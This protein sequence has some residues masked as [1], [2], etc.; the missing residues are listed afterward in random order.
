MGGIARAG[1]QGSARRALV[2]AGILLLV[3]ARGGVLGQPGPVRFDAGNGTGAEGSAIRQTWTPLPQYSFFVAGASTIE[4]LHGRMSSAMT[5]AGFQKGWQRRVGGQQIEAWYSAAD[6]STA[7]SVRWAQKG[8][9]AQSAWLLAGRVRA[10]EVGGLADMPGELTQVT[11]S[12][13]LKEQTPEQQTPRQQAPKQQTLEQQMQAFAVQDTDEQQ[14]QA[15]RQAFLERLGQL[16]F[17]FLQ[18]RQGSGGQDTG[19]LD[20]DGQSGLK[21]YMAWYQPDLDMTALLI[22]WPTGA[23]HSQSVVMIPQR[24]GSDEAAPGPAPVLSNSRL[25]VPGRP[26]LLI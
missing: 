19:S 18:R 26:Y 25:E 16:G 7:I 17:T 21:T 10:G 4:H 2:L 11:A 5:L 24:F 13:T 12:R 3:G 9:Y 6:D 23:G 15:T 14:Y 1:S 8:G 22:S 20:T